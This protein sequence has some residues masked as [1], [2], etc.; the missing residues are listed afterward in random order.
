MTEIVSWIA[1]V[2]TIGAAL[3]VASNLGSR[4]TGYGFAVFTIGSLAWLAL[5]LLTGQ[6]AL[7][8]TNIVMTGVN[9]FGVWRWLGRQA[10]LEEGARAAADASEGMPGEA[11]FPVSLLSGAPIICADGA[12]AGTSV[13]AMA[14]CTS[15]RLAYVV[16]SEGGVA[17]VGE[18]LR[19]LPWRDARVEGD[20][21]II[22][23]D[24]AAFDRLQP[25]SRDEW[26][27]R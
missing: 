6:Q 27:A 10:R 21:L 14:G 26:P 13:D 18:T 16:A 19:R 12:A 20:R 5:G 9:L 23:S 11:L 1:T 4:I 3:M 2:A 7:V 15:G 24:K 22:E 8:T 25:I 17:G